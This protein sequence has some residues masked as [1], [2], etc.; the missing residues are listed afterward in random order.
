MKK[1]LISF[2]SLGIVMGMTACSQKPA[3][4]SVLSETASVA[5]DLDTSVALS[6]VTEASS[7]KSGQESSAVSSKHNNTSSKVNSQTSMPS[8]TEF[9]EAEYRKLG[10]KLLKELEEKAASNLTFFDVADKLSY[11][12]YEPIENVSK[13]QK[14]EPCAKMND[15]SQIAAFKRSL[16]MDQWQAK[17]MK[18]KSMPKVFIYFDSN[19]HVNLEAQDVLGESWMSINSPSGSVYYTVPKDIYDT[20][21]EKYHK[22]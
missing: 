6:S 4:E 21:L 15:G 10:E 3:I 18:L 19:L 14:I 22:D 16:Q 2:L 11:Q 13:F 1:I 9:D 20:L 17:F 12:G 5:S 7:K 8:N